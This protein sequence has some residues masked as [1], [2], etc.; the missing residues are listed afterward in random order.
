LSCEKRKVGCSGQSDIE[1]KAERS[2]LAESLFSPFPGK[3]HCVRK[4]QQVQDENSWS[5]LFKV[6]A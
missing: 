1:R 5:S 4:R 3:L 6:R 2:G